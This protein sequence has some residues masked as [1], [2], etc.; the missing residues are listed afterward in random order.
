[1]NAGPEIWNQTHGRVTHFISRYY[2]I[3]L[4]PPQQAGRMKAAVYRHSNVRLL[5][6]S[7]VVG[8]RDSGY[9]NSRILTAP[10]PFRSL[11]TESYQHT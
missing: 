5:D 4:A 6:F 3:T 9:I 11:Y 2:I 7:I 1:M 8:V 10:G